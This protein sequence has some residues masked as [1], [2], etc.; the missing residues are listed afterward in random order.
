MPITLNIATWLLLAAAAFVGVCLRKPWGCCLELSSSCRSGAGHTPARGWW[1]F[2][3][4]RSRYC[5]VRLFPCW[6]WTL[7]RIVRLF[8]SL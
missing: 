5:S 2:Y 1:L 3:H 8:L 6:M 4:Y 7:C